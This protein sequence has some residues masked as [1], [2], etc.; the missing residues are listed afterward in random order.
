[1]PRIFS[2]NVMQD[3]FIETER[4][5]AQGKLREDRGTSER[6]NENLLEMEEEAAA[7]R[8]FEDWEEASKLVKSLKAQ[9]KANRLRAKGFTGV[10]L[11]KA[12]DENRVHVPRGATPSFAALN[13]AARLR[14]RLASTLFSDRAIPDPVPS[15]TEDEDRDKA[16]FSGQ[17]LLDLDGEGQL[18]NNRS[19]RRAFTTGSDYGSGFLHYQVD[20]YGG[21]LGPL[22][23][24]A[25]PQAQSADAPTMVPVLDL[26]SGQPIIGQDGQP[27]MREFEGDLVIRYVTE[28]Q[29]L[30]DDRKQ[31][32]KVWYPAIRRELLSGLHIRFHPSTS[33][34]IWES[35]GVS[36]GAMVPLGILKGDFPEIKDFTEEQL[37]RLLGEKPNQWEDLVPNNKRK[38]IDRLQGDERLVFVIT[39][40]QVQTQSYEK[41]AYLVAAGRD[42]ML[43]RDTWYDDDSDRPLDI[44]L[45][46]IMQIEDEDNPYGQG[47]MEFLGPGNEIRARILE[48]ILEHADKFTNRK[49][50]VPMTSNLQAK[51]L[52]SAT[53]TVIPIVPGGEPKYEELPDLPRAIEKIFAMVTDDLDDESGLQEAGQGLEAPNV[54]SGK[55]QQA[56]VAQVIIGLSDLRE[57]IMRAFQRSWRIQLQL[58]RANFDT[59]MRIQFDNEDQQHREKLWVGSDLGNTQDVRILRGSFTQLSPTQKDSLISKWLAEQRISP[60]EARELGTDQLGAYMGMDAN[61]HKTRVKRQLDRWRDGP[62]QGWQP[63]EPILNPATGQQQPGPDPLFEEI[64]DRSPADELQAIALIRMMEMAKFMS[65][66]DYTRQPGP[67]KQGLVQRFEHTRVS[68]GQF[69]VREQMKQ[70]Q[71]AAD[72]EAQEARRQEGREDQK[73][74]RAGAAQERGEQRKAQESQQ[75]RASGE[76]TAQQAAQAQTQQALIRAGAA[77][78]QARERGQQIASGQ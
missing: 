14:R 78:T 2:G 13:K 27:M 12:Q 30:V 41:G 59:P 43:F 21:G 50:F 48:M 69:T 42:M 54:T 16:Q 35:E 68:A 77:V 15:G 9:W 5:E 63:P 64:F 58:I 46:Q 52:Q 17:V 31:A 62:P 19:H 25:A 7:E 6:I 24:M 1:M 74:A 40:Y 23:V 10:T 73:E 56:I 28:Q 18:D 70:Q 66:V 33:V 71:D 26:Q 8:M 45:S 75:Q 51:Q 57:N 22:M 61:E 29:Q 20:P 3:P 37:G 76:A 34:D 65:T 67:W 49:T 11:V 38:K 47:I 36:I 60:Q 39:R 32:Q 44:P 53:G 4:D 55:Q 72:R